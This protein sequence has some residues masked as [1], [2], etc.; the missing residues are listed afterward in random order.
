M[1]SLLI[2]GVAAMLL[3]SYSPARADRRSCSGLS[4]DGTNLC[5]AQKFK[6]AIYCGKIRNKDLKWYCRATVQYRTSPS[7]CGNI[8]SA[9]LKKKCLVVVKRQRSGKK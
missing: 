8:K 1:R 2:L 6:N 9:A 3:G 5:L 4:R 7:I